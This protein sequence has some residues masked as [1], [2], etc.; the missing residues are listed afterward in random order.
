MIITD[1]EHDTVVIERHTEVCIYWSPVNRKCR[2]EE[3][4]KTFHW[5]ESDVL[6][7]FRPMKCLLFFFEPY[8]IA[9]TSVFL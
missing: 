8:G 6:R 1:T 3:K 7:H 4:K 9:R 2:R 5:L